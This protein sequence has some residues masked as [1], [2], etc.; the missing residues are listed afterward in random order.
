M[1]KVG[2]YYSE[3]MKASQAKQTGKVYLVYN[4]LGLKIRR[5]ID[6]KTG[7]KLVLS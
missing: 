6:K 3:S 5:V 2:T 4:F 1:A 7:K